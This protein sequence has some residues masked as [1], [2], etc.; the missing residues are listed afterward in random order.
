V[1][2][3]GSSHEVIELRAY[4]S[5][6]ARGRPFGSPEVDWFKAEQE[7]AAIAPESV[8]SK[9]ARD[10]GSALGNAV[11]LLSDLNPMKGEPS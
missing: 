11:A 7:L 8:L 3:P 6:E 5:W 4:Q 10:V 1:T 2:H 9:V